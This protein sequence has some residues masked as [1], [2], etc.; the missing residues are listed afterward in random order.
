MR[1][2]PWS[3][4]LA[5]I[6]GRCSKMGFVFRTRAVVVN[7]DGRSPERP[8]LPI[9]ELAGA[10]GQTPSNGRPKGVH[11]TL[12]AHPADCHCM[13]RCLRMVRRVR[14]GAG[15]D[16]GAMAV[17]QLMPIVCGTLL[18]WQV[19]L[20]C[21]LPALVSLEHVVGPPTYHISNKAESN[22]LSI[23]FCPNKQK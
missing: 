18:T 21:R 16:H 1:R 12:P 23:C 13:E 14:L 6:S 15:A 4:A 20:M 19:S 11:H 22:G 8:R 7:T 9:E 10:A 2:V 3:P 5:S 17:R